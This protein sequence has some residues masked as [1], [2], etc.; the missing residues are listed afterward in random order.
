[1]TC[2][3]ALE[4]SREAHWRGRTLQTRDAEADTVVSWSHSVNWPRVA[5]EGMETG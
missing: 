5:V 3:V 1:M 4:W 2:V